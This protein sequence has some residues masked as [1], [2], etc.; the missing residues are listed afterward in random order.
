[1][2][3]CTNGPKMCRYN[4]LSQSTPW[5]YLRDA[6]LTSA[7][8]LVLIILSVPTAF[9]MYKQTQ[10]D[11]RSPPSPSQPSVDRALE[12]QETLSAKEPF[13]AQN[14][15]IPSSVDTSTSEL[16]QLVPRSP[17]RPEEQHMG[18]TTNVAWEQYA[19]TLEVS[20]YRTITARLYL[21][22]CRD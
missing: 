11:S 22:C 8:P 4:S 16:V 17:N 9:A 13:V 5:L 14:E 15:L 3:T 1:M 10:I 7:L 19:G 18:N 6:D 2:K 20:V 12:L 21:S